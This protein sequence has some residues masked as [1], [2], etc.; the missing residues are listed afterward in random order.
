M[1][2]PYLEL[3][4]MEPTD[5]GDLWEIWTCPQVIR[6]TL[7]QPFMSRAEAEKK[8][9]TPPEGMFGLVAVVD[10]KVVGLSGLHVGQGRRRH[11]G[12]VGLTV[13]DAYVERGIGTALLRAAVDFAVNWLGLSRLEL[14]VYVDNAA[15]IHVYAKQGFV[16]EG[17]KRGYALR[18]GEYVD[19]HVMA[20][21]V[22]LGEGRGDSGEPTL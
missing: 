3:R 7:R 12:Q 2:E 19:A 16:I 5:F 10:G 9:A 11:V 8:V 13:H 1:S 4:A 21:V 20:R 6:G 17:T 15:A 18:D 22:E 14:E